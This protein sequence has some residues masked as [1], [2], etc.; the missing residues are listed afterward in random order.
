MVVSPCTFPFGYGNVFPEDSLD[1]LLTAI[2]STTAATSIYCG[3]PPD[4]VT[5]ALS[6]LSKNNFYSFLDK[7]T[8]VGIKSS[9][10]LTKFISDHTAALCNSI[11]VTKRKCPRGSINGSPH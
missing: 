2:A 4:A 8:N 9:K 5:V 3:T 1:N 11:L 7:T 10:F 6:A